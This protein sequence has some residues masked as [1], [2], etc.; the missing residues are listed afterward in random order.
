[1]TNE[2]REAIEIEIEIE[3]GIGDIINK[4]I[5]E[6]HKRQVEVQDYIL[7]EFLRKHGYRPRRTE[8]HM[9]NLKK[10]LEK[11]G[12][13]IKL[14]EIVLE[15]EYDEFGYRKRCVYVPSFVEKE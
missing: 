3:T 7:F 9:N 12:L 15:E 2:Q 1:M 10:K 6:L 5:S 4:Q 13:T 14:D 8:K 11:Q